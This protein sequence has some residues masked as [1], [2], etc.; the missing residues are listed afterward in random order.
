[1]KGGSKVDLEFDIRNKHFPEGTT[2]YNTV[3]EIVGTDKK[4]E[5]IM[6]GGHL[7]SWHS[8]TGTTDNATGCAVMMEAARILKAL[9]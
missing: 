8:A 5:V 6:L 2:A 7:D 1:M 3:A 4:D 9:E